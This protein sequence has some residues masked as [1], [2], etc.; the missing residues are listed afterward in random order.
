MDWTK[1]G[2]MKTG[3]T[4]YYRLLRHS[5]SLDRPDLESTLFSR[6]DSKCFTSPLIPHEMM[7]SRVTH[8][9]YNYTN[10]FK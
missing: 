2:W 4:H 10:D 1:T 6:L 8:G 5:R 9:L 7:D 3:R